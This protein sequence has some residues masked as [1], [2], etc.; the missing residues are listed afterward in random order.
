MAEAKKTTTKTTKAKQA[1]EE[2]AKL[3]SIKADEEIIAGVEASEIVEEAVAEDKTAKAGKRSAKAIKEVE[4][5]DAKEARKADKSEAKAEKPKQKQNP[6]RTQLERKSKNYRK[7]AELIKPDTTY[8]LKDAVELAQKTSP[9]KFDATVELHINLGVDPRHADQNI[10]DIVVLPA[11]T[12]K[13]VRVAVFADP[14]G[15][16]VAKKAGAEIAGEDAV[17]TLL[18]KG[19]LD[20]DVLIAPPMQ[21]AKLGKYAKQLGPKGLMPNPKSGTVTN[22]LAKAV[23]D[24][25]AGRVEFRVDT[26]GI[27][28]VGVGKVSFGTDKLLENIKAVLSSVK[29]AKPASLKGVYVKAFYITTSMGPSVPVNVS[30]V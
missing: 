8:S 13:S 9:V 30:E 20:F 14:E 6:P 7:L 18:D 19:N 24:A 2:R 1:A 23:K 11:G 4:E 26:T 16:A 25:K 5:K 27:V 17:I 3:A 28:H 15:A 12:G 21:M 29:A 10:R 22:D